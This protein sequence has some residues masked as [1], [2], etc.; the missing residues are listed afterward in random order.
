M[1][2][3]TD[4]NTRIAYFIIFTKLRNMEELTAPNKNDV[5]EKDILTQT[6][7]ELG[8]E[9][10]L[11]EYPLLAA[12]GAV[13]RDKKIKIVSKKSKERKSLFTKFLLENTN[14]LSIFRKLKIE[15]LKY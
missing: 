8:Y 7:E 6:I 9:H 13:K 5:K 11:H 10:K 12:I 15:D 2:T 4:L 1:I 3:R 14:S